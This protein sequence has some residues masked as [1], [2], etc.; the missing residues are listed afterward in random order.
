MIAGDL[1]HSRE[2][3]IT[4]A[5]SFQ[6]LTIR[7]VAEGTRKQGDLWSALDFIT[8]D[9]P[10]STASRWNHFGSSDHYPIGVTLSV[11]PVR[12]IQIR[13]RVLDP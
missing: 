11:K 2:E 6:N 8:S 4:K 12:K 3:L 9:G 5:E 7:T 1:N 13:Q 10:V